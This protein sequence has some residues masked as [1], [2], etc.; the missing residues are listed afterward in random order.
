[1]LSTRGLAAVTLFTVFSLVLRP[2]S[3]APGRPGR[4]KPHTRTNSCFASA[5]E[6]DFQ[7]LL[8]RRGDHDFDQAARVG[9]LGLDAG[10]YRHV[11]RIAPGG[12]DLVH[13]R[14]VANVG[15]PDGRGEN[16]R[17]VAAALG[18]QPVDF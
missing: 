2:A 12:P 8:F 11:L 16:L 9:E 10:A 1:M 18:K 6:A 7:N 13:R 15:N 17:L 5:P 3:A 14:T 4:S